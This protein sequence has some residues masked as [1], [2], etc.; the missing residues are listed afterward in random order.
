MPNSMRG[1]PKTHAA[2]EYAEQ[3]HSGQTR[4]ADGAP[5][6]LHPLE[7]ASL[8][9]ADGAPDHLIAA[10]A[11]H[12]VIEKTSVTAAQLRKRFGARVALVVEAVSE[13]ASISGYAARKAALRDQVARAGPEALRLFAADKISKVRELRLEGASPRVLRSR[14]LAHYQRCLALLQEHIPRS[15]LV[16]KLSEELEP[17]LAVAAQGGYR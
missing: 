11:L 8:L 7:V 4:R 10:G 17:H 2:F 1:L 14:R 15:P 9:H 13:D 5:F 3:L 16:A 12:D 6:V